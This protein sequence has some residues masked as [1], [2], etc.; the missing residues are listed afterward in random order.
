MLIV[1]RYEAAQQHSGFLV[2]ITGAVYGFERCQRNPDQG[3]SVGRRSF[4]YKSFP[5]T[6]LRFI[7]FEAVG[8]DEDIDNSGTEPCLPQ[9]VSSLRGIRGNGFLQLGQALHWLAE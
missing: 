6:I 4:Q 2:A 7:S 3:A 8:A 9:F 5:V 1:F